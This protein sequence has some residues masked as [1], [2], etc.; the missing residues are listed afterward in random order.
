M[1]LT[2]TDTDSCCTACGA[3]LDVERHRQVGGQP[4][5]NDRQAVLE[6]VTL[7]ALEAAANA[8]T[9]DLNGDGIHTANALLAA[10]RAY[11]DA[12]T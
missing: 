6:H 9:D 12:R 10:G 5:G 3:D 8:L 4:C 11:R 2:A 1:A 7:M